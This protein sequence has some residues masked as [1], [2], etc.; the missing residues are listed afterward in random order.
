VRVVDVDEVWRA[1]GA[2]VLVGGAL[3]D[4]VGVDVR[5]PAP[6]QRQLGVAEV[7][8]VVGQ[9]DAAYARDGL[10]VRGRRRRPRLAVVG[11]DVG[12]P[13]PRPPRAPQAH[14]PLQPAGD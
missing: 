3:D 14:H 5:E 12:E 8:L 10:E 11:A 1:R 9:D 2:D 7:R 4:P 6:R 13:L